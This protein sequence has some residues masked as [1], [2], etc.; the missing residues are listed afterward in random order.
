MRFI[1]LN[2]NKKYKTPMATILTTYFRNPQS[3]VRATRL[4]RF[5]KRSTTTSP[6]VCGKQ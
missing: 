6:D 5:T 1:K 2:I 3:A 4:K